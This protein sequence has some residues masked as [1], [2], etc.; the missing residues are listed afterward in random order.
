MSSSTHPSLIKPHCVAALRGFGVTDAAVRRLRVSALTF[1]GEPAQKTYVSYAR[2]VNWCR[3]KSHHYPHSNRAALFLHGAEVTRAKAPRCKESW[4]LTPPPPPPH[5][6]SWHLH[7]G[8]MHSRA[9][10]IVSC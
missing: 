1:K 4:P 7:A 10:A 8:I 6:F 9:C 2:D 3:R 5:M